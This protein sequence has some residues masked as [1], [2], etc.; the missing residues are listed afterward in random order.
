M[1]AASD[2]F[3][4]N[5]VTSHSTGSNN[6]VATQSATEPREVP[7]PPQASFLGPVAL[8]LKKKTGGARVLY[9]TKAGTYLSGSHLPALP[10]PHF[11]RNQDRSSVGSK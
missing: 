3:R 5:R 7:P 8:V 1:K 11:Y 9:Q 2:S 4:G 6:Q 10:T